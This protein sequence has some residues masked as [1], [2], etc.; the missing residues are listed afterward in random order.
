MQMAEHSR[1]VGERRFALRQAK[2]LRDAGANSVEALLALAEDE[3]QPAALRLAACWEL[4]Y[5]KSRPSGSNVRR[6]VRALLEVCGTGARQLTMPAANA[7]VAIGSRSAVLP[8]IRLLR[9]APR[10]ATREAAAYALGFLND[11]RA[12]IPLI[13]TVEDGSEHRAVRGQAAEALGEL[14]SLQLK[15]PV[16]PL[17]AALSDR[18]SEVRFWACYAL[19][20]YQDRRQIPSLRKLIHDR[21]VVKGWWS[22]GREAAWA[23]AVL[24]EDP[25]ADA[26]WKENTQQAIRGRRRAAQRTTPK[27]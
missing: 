6:A 18:S 16:K 13:S 4:G 24:S 19:S 9:H 1:T 27:G 22:V 5:G 11:R 15:R 23:I 26:I 21:A 3:K 8:L 20:Q 25:E 12:I 10:P 7:L 17:V 2:I 14:A